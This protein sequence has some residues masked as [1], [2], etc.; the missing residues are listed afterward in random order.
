[1]SATAFLQFDLPALATATLA[2]TLCALLGNFLVL[3]RQALL[4]DAIAHSVLPGIVIGFLVVGVRAALPMMAGAAAAAALAAMLIE[5]VRRFGRVEAGASMG[6]VFTVMFALGVALMEQ[7]AARSVDLD[8]DCVLYG[9]LE[10][11][12]WLAASDWSSLVDPAALADLPRELSTLAG[13]SAVA[14]LFAVLFHKELKIVAFDPALAST[15][16]IPAGAVQFGLT[17][18]VALAAIGSFE[19]VGSILVI[20]LLVCPAA[21][22]RMLTDRYR[23]QLGLSVAFGALSAILGYAAAALGPLWLGWDFAFNAAGMIAAA[24]GAILGLAVLFGRAGRRLR[25][26]APKA[27]RD[28]A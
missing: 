5:A 11:V 14:A 1:M 27:L 23:I 2:A 20:A 22:A 12:M 21:A 17:L 19:A 8:A 16:G 4:G 9:Q 6:V 15:L 18:F 28:A 26:R 13:L 25:G 24:S 3:R 10:D 7:A